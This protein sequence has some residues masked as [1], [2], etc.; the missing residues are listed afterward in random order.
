MGS[1]RNIVNTLSSSVPPPWADWWLAIAQCADLECRFASR[2]LLLDENVE[3]W[4]AQSYSACLGSARDPVLTDPLT[5]AF[6]SHRQYLVTKL[7]KNHSGTLPTEID[8]DE[9]HCPETFQRIPASSP[10]LDANLDLRL[11]RVESAEGLAP[12][13][14]IGVKDLIDVATSALA[15]VVSAAAT[16]DLYFETLADKSKVR[17]EF[18]TFHA[19][20]DDVLAEGDWVDRVRDKLG[21]IHYNPSGSDIPV[22]VFSYPIKDLPYLQGQPAFRPLVPP[23]VLESNWNAAFCPSPMGGKT[24]HTI[25]L[26]GTPPGPR[27]E[28]VHPTMQYQARHLFRVGNIRRRVERDTLEIARSLHLTEIRKIYNR[29]DYGSETDSDIV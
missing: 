27:R 25:D 3:P 13:I 12:R 18:A 6:P 10:F 21:L 20:I 1:T 29:L 8:L 28:V 5:H 15:G 24:G 2:N 26:S 14:G 7:W 11:V 19:D 4:R 17:P 23:V 22:L 9:W 16:L